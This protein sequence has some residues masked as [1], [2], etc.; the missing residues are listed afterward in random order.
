[1]CI[2]GFSTTN[3]GRLTGPDGNEMDT[4]EFLASLTSVTVNGVN[5]IVDGDGSGDNYL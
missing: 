5:P 4:E 2:T 3:A 1:L